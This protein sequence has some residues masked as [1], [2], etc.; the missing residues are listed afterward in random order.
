M[1]LLS[2]S[3]SFRDL[4]CTDANSG[5]D[6][7]PASSIDHP[8]TERVAVTDSGASYDANIPV[9]SRCVGSCSCPGLK[10]LPDTLVLAF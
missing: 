9:T 3:T 10:D 7:H 1:A 2:L 5:P 4:G 8:G 6:S